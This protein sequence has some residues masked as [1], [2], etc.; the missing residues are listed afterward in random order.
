[1]SDLARL[2]V[3]PT[4]RNVLWGL[5]PVIVGLLLFLLMVLLTPTVAPERVVERPVSTSRSGE[6]AR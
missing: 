6:V 3:R 1:M 4:N 2:R 5:G